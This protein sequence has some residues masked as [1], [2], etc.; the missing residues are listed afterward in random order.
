M[1]QF[2]IRAGFRPGSDLGRRFMGLGFQ[3]FSMFGD[4]VF[5]ERKKNDTVLSY[6]A[7]SVSNSFIFFCTR[8][9]NF[10]SFPLWHYSPISRSSFHYSR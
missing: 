10:Y 2:G 9:P 1:L 7:L 5:L 4:W 8:R 6:I 3:R